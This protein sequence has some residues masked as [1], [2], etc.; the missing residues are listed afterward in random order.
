M[1]SKLQ[2]GRT[3]ATSFAAKVV[4]NHVPRIATCT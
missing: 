1:S 3:H 2:Y 4:Y